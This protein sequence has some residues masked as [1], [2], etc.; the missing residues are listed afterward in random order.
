[1]YFNKPLDDLK[2]SLKQLPGVGEKTAQRFALFLLH[3]DKE[4]TLDLADTIKTAVEIHSFCDKCNILTDSNPCTICED[5][6][7]DKTLLCVVENTYD[8]YLIEATGE[9]KGYYFVLNNLLSPMEG[10][11]IKEIHLPELL[12][13]AADPEV[14]ELILALNPSTEGETTIDLIAAETAPFNKRVTRLSTGL[15][16]G[17]NIEYSNTLTLSNAIKRRYTI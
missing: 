14:E 6:S 13:R 10:I 9:Y 1:M 12:Q 8:V 7:R 16:F 15:P 3:Q 5:M 17:G 4:R 2:N 11:G